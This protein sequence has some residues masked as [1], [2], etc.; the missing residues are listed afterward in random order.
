MELD[1][2]KTTVRFSRIFVQCFNDCRL[3]Y[4]SATALVMVDDLLVPC[5]AVDDRFVPC[6][7]VDH[8]FV[9]SGGYE[10]F[11]SMFDG[12]YENS[13]YFVNW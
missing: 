7:A 4:G 12:G 9:V 2:R 5:S 3:L 11:V 1:P 13:V 10:D 6:R 8:G